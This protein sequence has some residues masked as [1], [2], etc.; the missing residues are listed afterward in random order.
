MLLWAWFQDLGWVQIFTICLASPWTIRY[1]SINF[2]QSKARAQ[3]KEYSVLSFNFPK[4]TTQDF[5]VHTAIFKTD[6]QQGGFP[7]SSTECKESACQCRRHRTCGLGRFSREQNGN[8]FQYSCLENPIDREAW[9]ATV[10]RVTRV[11]HDLATKQEQPTRNYC[12]SQGILLN[13]M[14]QP[15]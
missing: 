11:R 3:V 2:S 9:Q 7:G 10:H 4:A 5:D 15:G 12:I 1:Q 8:L 6:N 14:W 13:V